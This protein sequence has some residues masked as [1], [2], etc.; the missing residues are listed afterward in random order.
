MFFRHETHIHTLQFPQFIILKTKQNTINW[1]TE[2]YIYLF[3][4][5]PF[6]YFYL[7][8]HK[9]FMW[10]ETVF[11]SDYENC[12]LYFIQKNIDIFIK[13]IKSFYPEH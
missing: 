12:L 7:K 1:Q 8:M 9:I 13:A 4:T 6:V 10:K 3:F 2:K 11:I 5:F